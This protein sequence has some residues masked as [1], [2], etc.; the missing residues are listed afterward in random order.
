[1][2]VGLKQ[3]KLTES[4][5]L[6]IS[7]TIPQSPKRQPKMDVTGLIGQLWSADAIVIGSLV[8]R[9]ARFIDRR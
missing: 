4:T 5:R 1:M 3:S 8:M 2:M 9:F 7:I 6:I